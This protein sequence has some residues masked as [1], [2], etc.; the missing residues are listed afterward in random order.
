MKKVVSFLCMS[1]LFFYS[2]NYLVIKV[3]A[4][5]NNGLVAYWSF[6]NCDAHDDSGNGH[7]GIIHGDPE[8]IDG[9]KGKAFHFDGKDDYIEIIYSPTLAPTSYTV[10][11]FFK[12]DNTDFI[13]E[14]ICKGIERHYYQ[15]QYGN[16][17]WNNKI[18][19]WYE[20]K[21]DNDYSILSNEG[22]DINTH[23]ATQVLKRNQNSCTLIAYIDGNKIGERTFDVCPYDNEDGLYI[24]KGNHGYFKGI[25][26][27]IRIYNK[28]LSE[29]EIKTLY[30]Y[31]INHNYEDIKDKY[32]EDSNDDNFEEGFE[33]GKRWC[34]EHPQECGIEIYDFSPPAWECA[35]TFDMFTNTLRIPNFENR[36]WLE[37]KVINWDPV[38]LELKS[39]GLF[40]ESER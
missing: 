39:Y 27:E 29:H 6:D 17:T 8:C 9:I 24:A 4:D 1:L 2:L 20:D 3:Q 18:E 37:L 31:Y 12:A 7:N 5:T 19:F 35:A 10:I 32:Y 34:R 25:I 36:Y 16:T 33:E 14:I 40:H 38:Q 26:D 13:G 30:T 11:A 15:I 23:M 28:A 21:K 22:Y